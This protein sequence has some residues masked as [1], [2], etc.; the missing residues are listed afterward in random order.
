MVRAE[1]QL[2]RPSAL[3]AITLHQ[4]SASESVRV[5]LRPLAGM[6]PCLLRPA[7][8]PQFRSPPPHA[9]LLLSFVCRGLVVRMDPT[10]RRVFML[11]GPEDRESL[12][13]DAY[14]TL[15]GARIAA[16]RTMRGR[17]YS[18]AEYRLE[19]HELHD[20]KQKRTSRKA[21]KEG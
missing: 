1:G 11:V 13:P 12:S 3:L 20:A 10:T 5:E 14:P 17:A 2:L 4:P 9:F 7:P 15:H 16:S 19:F 18:V 21:K 8:H 6:P